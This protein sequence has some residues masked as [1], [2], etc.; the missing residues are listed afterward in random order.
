MY[1][2]QRFNEQVDTDIR[3]ITKFVE[4]ARLSAD[5]QIVQLSMSAVD[6]RKLAP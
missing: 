3:D 6:L 4:E 1:T 2:L 5:A